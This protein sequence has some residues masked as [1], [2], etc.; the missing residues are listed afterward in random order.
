MRCSKCGGDNR[1]GRKFCTNCGTSLVA[2]CPKC[3]A[4]VQPG[5]RFCG[6]CGAVIGASAPRAPSS[7]EPR[8][9]QLSDAIP[10]TEA[11]DG[12]RKTV[13]ALFADIKGSMELMEDLDPEEARG[14]IDP[15]L[16]LMIDAVHRYGGYIVQS[17]GDGIFALFGA[18]VGY[19]DHPQR[20]L[21]AALRIQDEMR[22]YSTRLREQ[23]ELPLEARIGVN[24]GEVVVRSITTSDAHAEYTPIGRSTSLA[25]RMQ[26]LAPTGSIAVTDATRRLCEGY[27]LFKSL[28]PTVVKGVTEPVTV[29]EVTGIGPLRTRLQ[30]AAARGL[31]KFVGRQS[32]MEALKHA[33]DQARAGH[34]QI[35][36]VMADPGVG[37][38]RLFY[39]FKAT[40][41]SGW[42][43]LEAYSVS[44]GKAWAYL[45]VIEL[46]SS[47][48]KISRDDD[49]RE[50]RE[51]I[52]GKVLGLDR[53]LEDALRYVYS[54]YNIAGA[55]DSLAQMDPQVRRR[56]TLDAI[57]RILLRES[58]NEPLMVVFEDLHWIDSETQALLNLL[59]DAIANAR[60][61]L[62]VNYRPEFRH[63]W[64][65]RTH[66]T[67]LRLD[68]LPRE[69]AEEMLSA[70]LGDDKDLIALKRLI[71]ER[72]D[73][74]P[75]F[76]EEI[77]Q[78]LFEEGVLRRNG[79]VALAR[80]ISAIKVPAT[81]QAVL[82]SRIDRLAPSE[83]E[84]LQTLAVLGREFTLT[85]VE[86]LTLKSSDQLEQMLSH[87][88]LGEFINE[89]PSV[90]GV[91]YIFKHA[92]TQEVTYNSLLTE[93]RRALH[94]R[95]GDAIEELYGVQLEEHYNDLA[96]HYL[97]SS[98]AAK[99]I[100][101]ARLAAEKAIGHGNYQAATTMI[102]SAL[103]AVDQLPHDA[104]RLQAEFEV[105]NI[106]A[107]AAFVLHGGGSPQRE[108][109]VRRMCELGE[110][111]G[112]GEH[113]LRGQIALSNIFFNRSEHARGLELARRCIE[114]V[115]TTRDTVLLADARLVAGLL[116]LLCGNFREAISHVEL[117]RRESVPLGPHV[118][119]GLMNN[120]GFPIHLA[121]TFQLLGRLGEA[122]RMAEEGLRRARE[123]NHLFSLTYALVMRARLHRYR[124]E[125]EA[126]RTW[127]EQGMALA[128]E[129]GFPWWLEF[130]RLTH[131]WALAELGQVDQAIAEQVAA[132][133]EAQLH[134]LATRE[135]E[136]AQLAY[137]YALSHRTGEALSL[138]ND[139]LAQIERTGEKMSQAEII[140]LKGEVL[141]MHD[142]TNAA[143][144]EACFRAALEVARAQ[145]AKWWELRATVN[146]A[147]L[148]RDTNRRDEA[149]AMLAEIYDWFTE[150]FDLPDLKDAKALLDELSS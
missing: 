57:K 127:S 106:E 35:V 121:V 141:L 6:D 33:A 20:A 142:P 39:E 147:R 32:E 73:G 19:E 13:T 42:M 134:G 7:A 65:N 68:P 102:E 53:N 135:T 107:S 79:T 119:G 28:G 21:Y 72:T 113:L 130:G 61:L 66:Y 125:L 117:A 75:F 25:A 67:Q 90:G 12:E 95:T 91:E 9:L 118:Q 78:S 87:L 136:R 137:C 1:E 58:L 14:I 103:K 76:I 86:R 11:L 148:L 49:E 81:V 96:Y 44:H 63:E 48:F 15:A 114:L 45:P 50:Q 110:E 23:G 80:P 41:Q 77:V 54:L 131:A 18:P 64:G 122:T 40:S 34:G 70:L 82:A 150:G 31:T 26:A 38:S 93:R 101:F 139:V 109:A 105:R 128:E 115:A 83:K 99:A 129:N 123:S 149:R 98:N 138:L 111:L 56:R 88:Q 74:T 104:E 97:R 140:R 144:A 116:A 2:I 120:V 30:L 60:I 47:Y 10:A 46:L 132:L 24:T 5:E 43:V 3:S 22:R 145:E 51:R 94:E 4:P 89:Q 16:K 8:P 126:A 71:I 133:A 146:L 62:L 55:G 29:Y 52:L 124:R 59:V 36:A 37:K 69:S 85:L 17:T 27:F 100:H 108:C 143:K 92:L 112:D 84:L